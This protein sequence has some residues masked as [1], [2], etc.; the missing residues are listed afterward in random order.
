[1]TDDLTAAQV[2]LICILVSLC[3]IVA[4]ALHPNWFN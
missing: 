3:A 2:G 1:M 4:V